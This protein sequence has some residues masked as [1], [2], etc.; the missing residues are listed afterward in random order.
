MAIYAI[1]DLHLSLNEPK[2]MDIFGDNWENHTKKIKENWIETVNIDDTVLLLGDFSWAMHLE[3]SKPDFEFINSLPGKKILL[4][5]NHDYWWNTVTCMKKYLQDNSFEDI[6]FLYNN[7]YCI[8]NKVIVGTRGWAITDNQDDKKM[9]KRECIRLELSLKDAI[10]KYGTKKEIISCLHYP[11][12]TK[13]AIQN[14]EQLYFVNIMKQYNV[15]KCLYGHLHG[16]NHEDAIEGFFD[17]IEFKLISSDYLD[18]KLY[19]V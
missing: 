13:S 11:P 19:K 15:T 4:K 10:Q 5:G 3:D 1:G 6:D 14:K 8:E 12:I 18:F 17:G 7:S 9:I 16:K 2:P